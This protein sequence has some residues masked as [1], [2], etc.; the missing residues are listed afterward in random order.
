M[1][2]ISSFVELRTGIRGKDWAGKLGEGPLGT[3]KGQT[4]GGVV[5]RLR[6]RHVKAPKAVRG[7]RVRP[8]EGLNPVIAVDPHRCQDLRNILKSRLGVLLVAQ[9]NEPN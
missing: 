5:R 7:N 2:Q 3:S 9:G 1:G 8:N 4:G 6:R